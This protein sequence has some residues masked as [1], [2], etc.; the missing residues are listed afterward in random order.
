MLNLDNLALLHEHLTALTRPHALAVLS[1]LSDQA[2][3]V[4][5]LAQHLN[6]SGTALNQA[7]MA[8]RKARMITLQKQEQHFVYVISNVQVDQLL[9]QLNHIYQQ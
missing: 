3:T 1:A 7:L 5:Q 4:D 8:L 2:L 9:Q 6:I